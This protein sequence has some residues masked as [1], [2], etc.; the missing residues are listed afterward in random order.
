MR[1]AVQ[2]GLI[3]VSMCVSAGLTRAQ[4]SPVQ[5]AEEEAVRR[6][7]AIRQLHLRLEDAKRF[8]AKGRAE[9]ANKNYEAAI[10]LFSRVGV[11]NPKVEA[12]KAQVVAGFVKIHLDFA[13]KAQSKGDLAEADRQVSRA[14]TIDPRNEALRTFKIANDKALRAQQGKIPD[15]DTV[16]RLP[17]F[18]SERVQ[19]YTLVQDAKVLI[20]A[21]KLDEAEAR[22]RQALKF[23]PQN[24]AASYYLDVVKETR[25]RVDARAREA[26]SKQA[27]ETVEHS[28]LPSD[29]SSSLPVPN[30]MARTNLVYSG[31][32]R[33][34]IKQKLDRIRLNEV[35]FDG[36]P[37]SA[38]LKKLRDESKARDPEHEGINFMINARGEAPPASTDPNAPPAAPAAIAEAVV[39]IDPPMSNM[40][41]ADVLDAICQ[42]VDIPITYDI[43]NFAVVF[44]PKPAA[45]PSLITRTVKVNPNTFVQGLI[46][47]RSLNISFGTQSAGSGGGSGG[48]GSGGSQSGLGSSTGQQGGGPSGFDL[49]IV[50]IAASATGAG[51]QGG[52]GGAGGVGGAGGRGV[53]GLPGITSTNNPS[54]FNEL[55]RDYFTTAGIDL[56]APK[57]VFFNERT[58]LLLLHATEEDI[59]LIKQA[60]DVINVAPPQVTIEAKFA[61]LT[62]T[63]SKA[64]GFD[65]ILGNTTFGG[66]TVGASGGSASQYASGS[67]SANPSGIF[68]LG[69]L[70]AAGSSDLPGLV[71]SGLRNTVGGS[72]VPEIGNITGILTQP[73][74][75]VIVHALEQREG[76][77][78]LAAPSVTTESG[79]QAHIAIQDIITV[80]S[81]VQVTSQQQQNSASLVGNQTSVAPPQIN[82]NTTPFPSGPALDVIPS[83]SSD[84]F[85]IQMVVL[86]T[87]TEFVGYDAPNQFVPQAQ[88]AAGSSLGVPLVA[89][90]PLPRIRL[91]QV[92]TSCNVWDGQTV[93]LGGMLGENIDKIKDKVPVLGDLPLVGRLFR[94]ESTQATKNNLMIFV[95]PTIVD[96]AGNRVHTESEL[97]FAQNNIPPQM[98]PRPDVPAGRQ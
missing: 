60:I 77:D 4:T 45:T 35:A 2:I 9:D 33:Q 95:T 61:E 97:P 50:S 72:T 11:G 30:M 92:T 41:M 3:V 96:P 80:V 12:D 19:S 98:I 16:S 64:L 94:S 86:P 63:D 15:Q 25:Y 22:L 75:Q 18:K 91:R 53:G 20:D 8:E 58:G 78:L 36:I 76:T 17:E 52:G 24:Q 49:P 56:A 27:M 90:L 73:Q 84:E 5:A 43:E 89:Y 54:S 7:D 32:G 38:V 21:G 23:Y 1:K 67:T 66:G 46:G 74:F 70:P 28:W 44:I 93:F 82:Y 81:S 55:V 10:N 13:T 48:G 37:L 51:A 14:L 88:G 59:N 68:P 65:W 40:R 71:T 83:V 57:F 87:Y 85:S 31:L 29:K 39:K 42:V 62:Q 34:Q 26:F 6:Q 79:R 69:G 47:V